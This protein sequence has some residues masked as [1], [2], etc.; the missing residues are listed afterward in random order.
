MITCVMCNNEKNPHSLRYTPPYGVSFSLSGRSLCQNERHC[1]EC[2][3]QTCAG[4]NTYVLPPVHIDV[5]YI[6]ASTGVDLKTVYDAV[7][8][9]LKEQNKVGDDTTLEQFRS[10]LN[11]DFIDRF[12]LEE[13]LLTVGKMFIKCPFA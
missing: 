8:T 6:A 12:D 10:M 11:E 2:L 9:V 1:D 5:A 4:C 13:S 7:W 3:F